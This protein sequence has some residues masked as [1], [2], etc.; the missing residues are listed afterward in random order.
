M[1]GRPAMCVC[2]GAP[3]NP[4]IRGGRLVPLTG[5]KA[6]RLL[7][8]R[9]GALHREPQYAHADRRYCQ[10]RMPGA[11]VRPDPSLPEWG[12]RFR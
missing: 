11:R 10:K 8:G 4:A 7:V 5:V 9:R 1:N 2:C 12:G 6:R 3:A